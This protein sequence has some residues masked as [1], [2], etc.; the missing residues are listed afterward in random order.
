MSVS[1][2]IY[3][4]MDARTAVTAFTSKHKLKVYLK[5]RPDVFA[6]PLVYTFGCEGCSPAIMTMSRALAE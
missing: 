3:L 5:R 4:V 2:Q 6:N 1:D